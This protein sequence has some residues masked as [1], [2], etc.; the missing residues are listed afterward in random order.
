M[1]FDLRKSSP[2]VAAIPFENTLKGYFSSYEELL[3][4]FLLNSIEPNSVIKDTRLR[5]G[6]NLRY[7]PGLGPAVAAPNQNEALAGTDNLR[8]SESATSD[9]ACSS[10]SNPT[11][12]SRL[13]SIGNGRCARRQ[14]CRCGRAVPERTFR[15]P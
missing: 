2:Q 7:R 6:V 10:T 3:L 1:K 4:Q 8:L 15:Q 11:Y 12:M 5:F 9:Y 13:P 14:L